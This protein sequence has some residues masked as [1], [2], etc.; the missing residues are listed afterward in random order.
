[1]VQRETP[2]QLDVSFITVNFPYKRVTSSNVFK[3]SPLHGVS[4]NNEFK[5]IFNP[6]RLIGGGILCSL[7]VIFALKL[8]SAP[9]LCTSHG[10]Q[11]LQT[12]FH[13]RYANKQANNAPGLLSESQ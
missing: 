12:L 1:M 10:A 8:L 7:T 5:I 4:Q 2:L 13:Q 6:K 9:L 11:A 3:A